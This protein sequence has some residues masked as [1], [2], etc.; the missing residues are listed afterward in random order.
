MQDTTSY[1]EPTVIKKIN[2]ETSFTKLK[3]TVPEGAQ[4]ILLTTVDAHTLTDGPTIFLAEEIEKIGKFYVNM[5]KIPEGMLQTITNTIIQNDKI[6]RE[7]EKIDGEME[8]KLQVKDN[9]DKSGG[10]ASKSK[11]EKKIWDA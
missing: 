8:K 7:I 4:G 2:S 3:H 6:L 9:S 5:S 11:N 1:I 10:D